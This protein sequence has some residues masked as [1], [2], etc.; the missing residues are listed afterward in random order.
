MHPP[1]PPSPA[2][3]QRELIDTSFRKLRS[4]EGAFELLANFRSI[5]SRGAIRQQM[6]NKLADILEQFHRE[7]GAAGEAFARGAGAPPTARNMP[8]VAGARR[9]GA[10][11]GGGSRSTVFAGSVRAWHAGARPLSPLSPPTLR[12]P[13]PPAGAIHWARL[14]FSRV[15]QTMAKLQAAEPD[16]AWQDMPIGQQ[17]R[18]PAMGG[19]RRLQGAR[20]SLL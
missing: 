8:P 16:G 3:P 4:A 18:P 20:R 9:W 6:M 7:V 13:T 10:R 12:C 11:A 2:R 19:Q 1:S 14:L 17:A 5:E 15:K